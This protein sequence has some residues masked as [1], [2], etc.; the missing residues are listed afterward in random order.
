MDQNTQKALP[1]AYEL[2]NLPE[3][4]LFKEQRAGP[5]DAEDRR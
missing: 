5:A 2:V 1:Q 3:D 4:D